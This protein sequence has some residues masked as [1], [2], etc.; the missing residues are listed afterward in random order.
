M[1]IEA[2]VADCS[3]F[4]A[5]QHRNS[6]DNL[7][8]AGRLRARLTV[9]H[10]NAWHSGNSKKTLRMRR[11]FSLASLGLNGASLALRGSPRGTG[12]GGITVVELRANRA[13]L[14]EEMDRL[15][16]FGAIGGGGIIRLAWSPEDRE[17][18][19]YMVSRMEAAGL[20]VRTDPIGNVFGRRP[21]RG[22]D[23]PAV[24]SGSHL[25]SELP[26][27]R[28]DGVVGVVCA[29]EALR[30][31]AEADVKT[32]HP[33]EAAIIAA[34]EG[35]RFPLGVLGS[36]FIAGHAGEGELRGLRDVSGLTLWEQL[37]RLG[38]RPQR[39]SLARLGRDQV[40]AFV[41]VHIEQNRE[42]Q[43]AG[44]RI[45]IVHTVTGKVRWR[46]LI[47]G[48]AQHSGGTPMPGR[49]DALCA[50]AEVVLAVEA[51]ASAEREAGTVGTVGVLT[52]EPSRMFI[53]P[54]RCELTVDLRSVD[55]PSLKRA[56][57]DVRRRL[58]EI[59]ERR[60]VTITPTMIEEGEPI[61]FSS[62]VIGEIEAVCA[63]LGIAARRMPSRGGHDAQNFAT[64]TEAGMIFIPCR[65]GISHA[66]EEF[67]EL[68]DICLGAE[69]LALTLA[70]LAGT[71]DFPES[72]P[73]G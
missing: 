16:T 40:R 41:E 18:C 54:G 13:R 15:A 68:E 36:R 56:G 35:S 25:D 34:E 32:W 22:G 31:L 73:R 61:L 72:G 70:R 21:G 58:A 67:A 55:G 11:L 69:V 43:D 17:A 28:F 3:A 48:F 46:V 47:E 26:G 50:A 14:A 19:G 7:N 1:E 8:G 51:A 2:S 39:V 5:H 42:L 38:L 59:A 24:I 29:L 10:R 60:R 53:I 45:G 33:L 6:P 30:I 23:L 64:F 65:D 62:W 49:R 57:G 37:E 66:P 71:S 63:A 27:G 52:V 9:D 20:Q 44:Q 4:T 12:R